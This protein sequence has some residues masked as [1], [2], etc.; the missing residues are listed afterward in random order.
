MTMSPT[1][2]TRTG[3]ASVAGGA[4]ADGVRSPAAAARPAPAPWR[5]LEEPRASRPPRAPPRRARR[6][7][8][9]PSGERRRTTRAAA[10]ARRARRGCRP[11]STPPI[12][13]PG[14]AAAQD[15]RRQEVPRA[16]PTPAAPRR[17]RPRPRGR[18]RQPGREL[19]QAGGRRGQAVGECLV[20]PHQAG[21]EPGVQAA[22]EFRPGAGRPGAPA[23]LREAHHLAP[24]GR[25]PRRGRGRRSR[26]RPR[27]RAA[28]GRPAPAPIPTTSTSGTASAR[29]RLGDRLAE[30]PVGGHDVVARQPVAAGQRHV[31]RHQARVPQHRP[32]A[33]RAAHDLDPLGRGRR[34]RRPR[35]PPPGGRARAPAW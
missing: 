18:R 33:R 32:A 34:R 22:S 11:G 1:A 5:S 8:S 16:P 35:G 14:S 10:P 23:R 17:H 13:C 9:P 7:R 20:A 19:A 30:P 28:S 4:G 21:Q 25:A 29:S 6:S 24:A 3:V 27:G 26:R 2:A 31:E 15:D 12:L